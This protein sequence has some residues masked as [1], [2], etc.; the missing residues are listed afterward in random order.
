MVLGTLIYII[1]IIVAI[2]VIIALLKF[3]FQLFFIAPIGIDTLDL[4]VFN[5]AI[6]ALQPTR[7]G[8][9]YWFI[10]TIKSTFYFHDDVNQ[11]KFISDKDLSIS[12]RHF[13]K[14]PILTDNNFQVL[15]RSS[16]KCND[17]IW[18]KLLDDILRQSDYK[19]CP[20]RK[21]YG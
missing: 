20:K 8:Y 17:L 3:L 11:A 7:Q 18:E 1:I 12:V 16:S 9:V 10:R 19:D 15:N 13:Q 4:E 21:R 6:F 2:I 14:L 5:R